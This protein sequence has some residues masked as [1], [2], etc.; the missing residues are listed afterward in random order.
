M[1]TGMRIIPAEADTLAPAANTPVKAG[2]TV[3]L[4]RNGTQTV[5]VDEDVAF[6]TRKVNDANHESGY[7][8]VQTQGANGKKTVTYEI[9]MRDGKEIERRVVN[10][11][12]VKQAVEQVEIIGVRGMYTTP[13]ENESI[14]WDFLTGKGLTREQAAGIMGNLMQEHRFNTTGDGLAQWTGS[15]QARLRSMYPDTYMTIDSQLEYLWYELTG[16]YATVLAAIRGAGSVEQSVVIF[17][18]RF[19]KCGV[20]AESNRTQYAYNILASH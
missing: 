18:N 13:T 20:C 2:M 8:E 7:K 6:T 10:E 14:A 4:W 17:Q 16:P 3:Q 5:T 9:V 11:V 19:E 1:L 15:R 12:T